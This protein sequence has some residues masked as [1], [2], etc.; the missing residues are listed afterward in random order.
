[1]SLRYKLNGPLNAIDLNPTQD[2]CVVAGR[3]GK[4]TAHKM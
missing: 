3:E 4:L 1:M 2:H